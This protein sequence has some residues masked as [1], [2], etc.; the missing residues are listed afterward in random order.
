MVAN[1]TTSELCRFWFPKLINGKIYWLR[2][3]RK[4]TEYTTIVLGKEKAKTYKKV[5]Y[6]LERS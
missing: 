1:K 6:T 5:H 4:I 3:G 2:K